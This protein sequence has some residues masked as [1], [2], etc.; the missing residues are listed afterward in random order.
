MKLFGKKQNESNAE[1]FENF[2]RDVRK[3]S[4]EI[5]LKTKDK[6]GQVINCAD[7]DVIKLTSLN[8]TIEKHF[9]FSMKDSKA[10]NKDHVV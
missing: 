1:Q 5:K 10:Y 3:H 2:F 8:R 6:E 9:G 4:F 7:C